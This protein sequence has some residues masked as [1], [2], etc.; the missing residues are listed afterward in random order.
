MH[1]DTPIDPLLGYRR[2]YPGTQP[3]YLHPPYAS[4]GARGPI[5]DPIA[6]PLTLSEATGPTLDRTTLGDHAADLTAGFPGAPLGERIIVSGRLLDENG[7]PVRNSVVEVWQCNA[8]GRYLHAG[9]QHDAPLDPNF[10]GT[11]QVLTD[12]HGRYRFT[13][14]KPGAYPWRNHYN[15]WRPAHIHFSLHGDGI[16]Q[17]LVTQMYFPGDPLLAFD[18]IFNCVEDPKARERMVSAFDWENTAN[19][20]ALGYRFDIVLRGRKQTPWE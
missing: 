6:I 12:D 4:T 11:G 17:R 20:F 9:D 19:E 8:A 18:P 13:T 5:R 2:P 10:T 7:K 15:A 14:I 3:A 16:G 1:D